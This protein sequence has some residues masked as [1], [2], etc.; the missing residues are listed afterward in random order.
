MWKLLFKGSCFHLN[1]NF[2]L[3]I[4]EIA[5]V[6]NK[7]CIIEYVCIQWGKSEYFQF[8]KLSTSVFKNKEVLIRTTEEYK[9]IYTAVLVF[10]ILCIYRVSF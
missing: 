8:S 9:I 7:S 3:K 4:S 1:A 5:E 6:S 10:L 2:I